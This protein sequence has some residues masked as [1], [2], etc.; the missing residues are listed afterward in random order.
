MRACEDFWVGCEHLCL[1]RENKYWFAP[2]GLCSSFLCSVVLG[3]LLLFFFFF[4]TVL[5][6]SMTPSSTHEPITGD[7][8]P[9]N[10][11]SQSDGRGDVTKWAGIVSCLMNWKALWEIRSSLW[12]LGFHVFILTLS[13]WVSCTKNASPLSPSFMWRSTGDPFTSISTCKDEKRWIYF[14]WFI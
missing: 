2:G 1:I 5:S 9:Q 14:I 3:F 11:A 8:C 10:T 12:M 4:I 13:C 7:S 6:S